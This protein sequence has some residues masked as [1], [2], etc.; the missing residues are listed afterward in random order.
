[1][2][3]LHEMRNDERIGILIADEHAICREAL[4]TLFEREPG[5]AIVGEASDGQDALEKALLLKPQVVLL[6]LELPRFSAMDLLHRFRELG[7]TA[8]VLILAE[9]MD[10]AGTVEALKLGAR[11]VVLKEASPQI[12]FKSIR[13]VASGEYWIGR[14]VVGDLV[15]A[16]RNGVA[17]RSEQRPS[18]FSLTPRELEII[19]EVAEGCTNKYIAEKLSIAEQTVKHHLTSIFQ[20]VGVSNRLELAV[21]A[22]HRRIIN[23]R[24]P[25]HN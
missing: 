2:E 18:Q 20:K 6:D 4:H 8:P 9:S 24:Q 23:S 22:M 10:A 12:L 7:V 14:K 5:L 3:I 1:M 11:G 25:V 21:F 13:T 15:E 19:A 17:V 16:L